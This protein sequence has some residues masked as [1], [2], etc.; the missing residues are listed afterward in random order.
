M[1]TAAAEP[2]P[3][4]ATRVERTPDVTMIDRPRA[5]EPARPATPAEPD[6]FAAW[7][8][9]DA[10]AAPRTE[11]AGQ[12]QAAQ[13][14][15]SADTVYAGS[16]QR[17]AAYPPPS[18]SGPGYPPSYGAQPGPPPGRKGSSGGRKAAFIVAVALVMLAAGGGAYALVSRSSKQTAAPPARPTAV[19]SATPTAPSSASA[20]STPT[21]ASPTP[22][23][24]ASSGP[25][26]VSLGSGVAATGAEPAVETTL[27]RYFQGINTH[28]YAEY[29]SAHNPHEQ[30]IESESDFNSGYGSTQ[31]SGMTLTSLV[32]TASGESATV[33]FTSHQDKGTGIDGS[34]CN[35]WQLT[36]F[37]VP[38][39]TG[40]LIGPAPAGYKPV[41]SDC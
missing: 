29:Q 7:F 13:P 36:Y 38:Q 32:S 30:A 20:S 26:L 25:S 16:G 28:N 3:A 6:P 39:G 35:N 1:T 11:P 15:Q 8:A 4:D 37:L 27:S 33:T 24:T 41:Y 14:W 34:A 21:A 17:P 10:Q 19:S 23:A 40:Y 9:P 2:L 12:R 22:S 31:D 18:P 5:A